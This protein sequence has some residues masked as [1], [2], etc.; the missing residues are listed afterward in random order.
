MRETNAAFAAELSGHYYYREFFTAESSLWTSFLVLKL[1]DETKQ[2]LS[3]L[4]APM[5]RY[6]QSGEINF[7]VEDKEGTLKKIEA[8]YQKTAQHTDWMDGLTVEFDDW[9]F[10]IRPSN[11]EPLLRLNLEANSNDAMEQRKKEIMALI[12]KK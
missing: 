9:W 5:K 1:L 7:T 6:F 3:K 11:T 2:P 10:N 4:A 8:L 12:E